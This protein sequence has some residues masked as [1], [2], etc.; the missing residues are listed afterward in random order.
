M[1]RLLD[2]LSAKEKVQRDI[3]ICRERGMY[4][5]VENDYLVLLMHA[6]GQLMRAAI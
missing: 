1:Q 3:A 2:F 4:D 6:G 5:Y